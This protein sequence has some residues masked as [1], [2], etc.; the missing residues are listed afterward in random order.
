MSGI[1]LS[2]WPVLTALI[3]LMFVRRITLQSI[4]PSRCSGEQ[5]KKCF[6]SWE[7]VQRPLHLKTDNVS[8]VFKIS[9]AYRLDQ[10]KD[11]KKNINCLLRATYGIVVQFF[12]RL[13][14]ASGRLQF[15]DKVFPAI[16]KLSN[17][18]F[19]LIVR[20]GFLRYLKQ[21]K[22]K[23]RNLVNVFLCNDVLT[24]CRLTFC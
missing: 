14:V 10:F 11:I 4:Q 23:H 13:S 22:K 7:V 19:S 15:L 12:F 16:R 5:D 8:K 21:I 2:N 18:A 20:R 9:R 1:L 17:S 24:L 6:C 3:G